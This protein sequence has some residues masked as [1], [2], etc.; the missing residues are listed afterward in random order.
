[1]IA[2]VRKTHSGKRTPKWHAGFLK[3]LPTIRRYALAAFRHLRPEAREEA[4][5]ECVANAVVAYKCL[6][7]QGRVS[8]A[9]ATVLAMYG[10]K[11]VKD[12]RRVG[13]KLNVREVLSPYAQKHKGFRVERLDH[14]DEETGEWCEVLVEDRT[15]GPAQTAAARID[16]GNWFKAMPPRDRKIAKSLAV[17]ER[18]MDV[19]KR[20]RLS[21]GRISQKRDEFH[22]SWKRFQGELPEQ[23][24]GATSA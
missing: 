10:I 6:Y 16:V 18:T 24:G 7:D 9:Y 22:N 2:P 4:A 11:Q 14:L 5:E 21:Q 19:A 13:N 3:M 15:A 8:I 20:F 17:G 23:Q 12:G 1:M